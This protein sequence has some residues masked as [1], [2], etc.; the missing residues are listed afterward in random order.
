MAFFPPKN[1]LDGTI[2]ES[3]NTPRAIGWKAPWKGGS[4]LGQG[5]LDK[6]PAGPE[7]GPTGAAPCFFC[8]ALAVP[9]G[10]RAGEVFHRED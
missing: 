5:S 8:K 9:Q 4:R 10:W 2:Y 3:R 6:H 1:C 7:D